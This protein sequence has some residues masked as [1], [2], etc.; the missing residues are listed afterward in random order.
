MRVVVKVETP[1]DVVLGAV[2]KKLTGRDLEHPIRK[3]ETIVIVIPVG[4]S[5]V[6]LSQADNIIHQGVVEAA[7]E[8]DPLSHK[9][10]LNEV[11]VLML[12][13][14]TP[15][16]AFVLLVE[17]EHFVARIE[18]PPALDDHLG[19]ELRKFVVRGV[20]GSPLPLLAIL[21]FITHPLDQGSR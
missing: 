13:F 18:T 20:F 1:G 15:P 12:V 3:G 17:H 21:D 14:F 6:C 19:S 11:L 16:D 8:G 7:G 2:L 10:I 5:D 4:V 9:Q